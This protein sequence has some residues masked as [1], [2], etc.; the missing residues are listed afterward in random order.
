MFKNY[1]KTAWR[2]LL[3]NKFYS[4]IN[5]AGLSI[6]LA[7]GILILLWVKDELSFDTLQKQARNIYR[8]ENQVGTGSSVQIW[9]GTNAPIGTEAKNKLPQ[10][11]ARVRI[12]GNYFYS[13]YR[14]GD[15]I[16]SENKPL[17]TDPSF[18]SIFDFSLVR[19]TNAKP[20]PEENSIVLAEITPRRDFGD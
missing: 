9:S 12:A 1:F 6:G 3:K 10:V 14:Y 20:F 16:F 19:G 18:F 2:R 13:A 8:L 15:K 5:I 7:V 4:F 11:K 17:F